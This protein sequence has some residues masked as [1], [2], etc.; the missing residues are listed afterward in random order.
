MDVEDWAHGKDNVS[1]KEPERVWG[2]GGRE[3]RGRGS[4]REGK[5][6]GKGDEGKRKGEGEGKGEWGRGNRIGRGRVRGILGCRSS[7]EELGG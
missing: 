3:G 5:G 4:G 7:W 6:E 2:K 1:G